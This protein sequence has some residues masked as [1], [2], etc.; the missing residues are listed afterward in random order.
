MAKDNYVWL[1]AYID[2]SKVERL[3]R[4]IDKFPE[5]QMNIDAHVP[6]VRILKKKFKGKDYFENVPL[7][8]NY[9]FFRIPMAWA[10]NRDILDIMKS[11]ITCIFGWVTDPAKAERPSKKVE[12]LNTNRKR[13]IPYAYCDESTVKRLLKIAKNESIH[14]SENI[15]S[16]KPG[17]VINLIGYPFEGMEAV[18]VSVDKRSKRVLVEIG[19]LGISREVSVSFDNVFYSIYRGS[20]EETYN[21]EQTLRDYQVKNHTTNEEV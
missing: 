18:I 15:D 8:F 16:L 14:S 5:Y 19:E 9:G 10:I 6:M 3:Q 17:D 4:D 1:I 20:Y 12:K 13:A 11:N 21:Q 2:S 7:L